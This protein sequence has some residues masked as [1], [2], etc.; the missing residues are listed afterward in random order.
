[1]RE[2]G[3]MGSL[4]EKGKGEEWKGGRK[5]GGREGGRGRR[6]SERFVITECGISNYNYCT[7]LAVFEITKFNMKNTFG[8]VMC[9]RSCHNSSIANVARLKG[10]SET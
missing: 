9:I 4:K 10:V 1:M 3:W 7:A 8:N 5:G 2:N 6:K